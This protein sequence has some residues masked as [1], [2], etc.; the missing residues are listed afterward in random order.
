MLA[1]I[2]G[3]DAH[4]EPLSGYTELNADGS[5]ACGCW[6][7]C[8]RLRR[9]GQPG[10]AAQA[11]RRAELGG[12]GVGLGV[13]DEP[14]HPLQPR[15]GRPGRQAVERA[16]GLRLVGR[17]A[18]HLDRARRTRTSRPTSRP[19]TGRPRARTAQDAI[20]GDDPFIM[21][22]DGKAWLYAPAGLAGRPAAGALRAG[23]VARST[24]RSTAS[25]PTR[26]AK[27]YAREDNPYQPSGSRP[28]S[29]V[30]PYVFTTY[31]LTE[32]HTA[33]G[34]S[35]FLSY[36]SELQPEFFCEVSP[37]LAAERGLEH[38]GWATIVTAA[39][40]SRPGCW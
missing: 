38:L 12:T 23:G 14:A 39:P 7:Y 31:R 16:Q 5:T 10:R 9:R 18:G 34:M 32:H 27:V 29:D 3:R 17:G 2:N 24:T 36:L 33:G 22:A 25:R 1:E 28:G 26:P 40:R 8:R 21:Q 6:I 4:G 19:T 20:A 13:A 30:F 35:R 37:E 15:L 11:R